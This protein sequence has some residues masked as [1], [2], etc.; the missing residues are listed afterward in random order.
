MRDYEDANAKIYFPGFYYLDEDTSELALQENSEWRGFSNARPDDMIK[1]VR[2]FEDSSFSE[3]FYSKH[4]IETRPQAV[5][6]DLERRHVSDRIY[7]CKFPVP[8]RKYSGNMFF[9]DIS[10]FFDTEQGKYGFQISKYARDE[11]SYYDDEYYLF[12]FLQ[13]AAQPAA[14]KVGTSEKASAQPVAK[15]LRFVK[16]RT[17]SDKDIIINVDAISYIEQ[18]GANNNV[19]LQF[20]E[21]KVKI[22][23]SEAEKVFKIIGESFESE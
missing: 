22:P 18:S 14:A 15:A 8:G 17:D 16:V 19:L 3:G 12:V 20:G 10:A 23:S 5:Y 4:E 9:K 6:Q 1:C 21:R 11:D 2:F 7:H 13:E